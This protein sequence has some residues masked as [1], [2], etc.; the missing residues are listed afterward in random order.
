MV[1]LT[2]AKTNR[3]LVV[4]VAWVRLQTHNM[5]RGVLGMG[6]NGLWKNLLRIKIQVCSVHLIETPKKILSCAVHVV[7]ARVVW[8]VVAQGRAG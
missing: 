6:R 8:E 1:S 2:A 3:M 4:S 7:A 5:I